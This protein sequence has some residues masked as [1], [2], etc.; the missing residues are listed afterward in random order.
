LR[1]QAGLLNVDKPRGWTSQ[2]VCTYMKPL[3][4]GT[5]VG[6]AGTLD[7]FAQGVLLVLFGQ[8]TKL[9]PYHVIQCFERSC[10]FFSNLFVFDI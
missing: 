10:E 1:P 6:H 5:K 2:G 3:L 8:A 4:G 7:P 9:F